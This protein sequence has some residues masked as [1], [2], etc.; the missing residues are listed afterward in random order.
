MLK[1]CTTSTTVIKSL[2]KLVWGQ[3]AKARPRTRGGSSPAARLPLEIVEIIV[4]H[5]IYDIPSLLACSLTCYVW[6]LAA[7]PHLHHTLITAVWSPCSESDDKFLWPGPIQYFHKFGLLPLVKTFK[8]RG[9][10]LRPLNVFSPVVGGFSPRLFNRRILRQFSALTNV[11]ELGIEYLDI[12][13]F[14]PGIRQYFGHFSPTVR[15]LALREPKGSRRQILYFVGLFQHLEDL[16]LIYDR[17]DFQEESVDDLGLIPPSIPPL[18]GRLKLRHFARVEL[19]KDMI[20]LFGGVRF[21]R[22]DLCDVYGMRLLLDAC[23]KTLETLRVYPIDP[24]CENFSGR[25]TSS[26][27]QF[28]QLRPPVKTLTYPETN[29]SRRSRSLQHPSL[30]GT[31][32]FLRM[33]SQPS[34]LAHHS[35]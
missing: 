15:S 21:H 1:N 14:M 9:K 3:T 18:R 13:K 27:Q 17:L 33:C 35:G 22:M 2:A 5:L 26:G 30:V 10:H 34:H 16:E 8:V 7:I 6:Y 28:S 29:H 23:A 19:L 20:D 24:R 25:P 32:L 11:Q 12:P 31:Q 4:A